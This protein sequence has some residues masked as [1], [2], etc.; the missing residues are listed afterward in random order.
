MIIRSATIKLI[1]F[2][3]ILLLLY[4]FRQPIIKVVLDNRIFPMLEHT[5]EDIGGSEVQEIT[6]DGTLTIEG[7]I[8]ETNKHRQAEK[9]VALRPDRELDKA[10]QLKLEDLFEK[11]YFA[12]ISPDGKGPSD[13]ATAA[14]YEYIVVA[15]NLALGDFKT[16]EELVNSWMESAGH[17]ANIMD[18]DYREIGVAVGKGEYEGKITWI[19]V[20][21]FGT[22]ITICGN[23]NESR[24][25]LI[26]SYKKQL[27][28]WDIELDARKERMNSLPQ[29]SEEHQVEV[30]AY[31]ELVR[32]YNELSRRTKNLSN[33][34]NVEATTYNKCMEEFK[35]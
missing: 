11:D 35:D 9:L 16:D 20:Q 5:L 33:E 8:N 21:E 19:A 26:E 34:Y 17:R 29:N 10:A 30:K 22:P 13:L 23:F 27:A 7:V 18:E 3:V 4:T 12:H 6:S 24:K 2:V 1:V 14:H 15:E 31:N 28:D 32:E 25:T